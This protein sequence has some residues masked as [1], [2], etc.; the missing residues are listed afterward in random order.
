MLVSRTVRVKYEKVDSFKYLGS[1]VA[2][3]GT[4]EDEVKYR[5]KEA[6]KCMG[7]MKRVT[8]NRALGMSAKRRLYEGVV[9][10]RRDMEY[11]RSG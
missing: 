3:T 2:K 1:H 4:V 9:V 10:L 8:S 5:K 11:E 6:S 7:G